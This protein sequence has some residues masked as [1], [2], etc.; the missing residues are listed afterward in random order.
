MM[1]TFVCSRPGKPKAQKNIKF[2]S[3]A[4]DFFS[5]SH[6]SNFHLV[7]Q[8]RRKSLHLESSGLGLPYRRLCLKDFLGAFRFI[9]VDARFLQDHAVSI[10]TLIEFQP[11]HAKCLLRK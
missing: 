7:E 4:T 3:T 1:L 10:L 9:G 8:K 5:G 2:D 11:T 6:C